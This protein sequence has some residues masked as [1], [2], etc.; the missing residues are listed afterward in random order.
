MKRGVYVAIHN[1]SDIPLV[2]DEGYQIATGVSANLGI[3]RTFYY[4]LDDPFSTCRKHVEVPSPKDTKLFV[5]TKKFSTYRQVICYEL[6]FQYKYAIPICNC[7]DPSVPL[8]DQDLAVCNTYASLACI[9]TQRKLFDNSPI[10]SLCGPD[11]PQECDSIVY[12]VNVATSSY[13]SV[14]Y[15]GILKQQQTLSS[16]YVSLS[17]ATLSDDLVQIFVYFD[18]LRYISVE[19]SQTVTFDTLVGLVGK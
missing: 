19:E 18:T 14:Y 11:C 7:S 13:P 16:K 2:K 1:Q 9:S 4:R 8:V 17:S 12:D 3:R 15:E 5:N 6:C 10:E